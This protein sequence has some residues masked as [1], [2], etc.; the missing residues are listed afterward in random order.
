MSN[1]TYDLEATKTRQ[2][3]IFAPI[4]DL[5]SPKSSEG[6]GVATKACIFH[7]LQSPCYILSELSIKEHRTSPSTHGWSHCH[8]CSLHTQTL[9]FDFYYKYSTTILTDSIDEE[10]VTNLNSKITSV[11]LSWSLWDE[12]FFSKRNDRFKAYLKDISSNNNNN[13]NDHYGERLIPSEVLYIKR[14]IFIIP[15]ITLH[16]GMYINWL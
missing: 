11:D 13:N 12:Y 8:Y 1:R 10:I 6:T 2:D 14:P 15:V 9:Q 3:S 5:V 4:N 16:P 7:A